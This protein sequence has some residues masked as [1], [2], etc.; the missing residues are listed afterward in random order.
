MSEIRLE[1]LFN[2]IGFNCVD[3]AASKHYPEES[4]FISVRGYLDPGSCKRSN[5]YTPTRIL[6]SG[7]RTIVFWKDGTKTI[8]K[9]AEDE[10]DNDYAAYTAALAIKIHGSNS[11]LKRIV[12]RTETQKQKKQKEDDPNG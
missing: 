2:S 5:C 12:K 10:E 11:A 3:I 6:K 1:E 4:T 9:R 7:D 8:V